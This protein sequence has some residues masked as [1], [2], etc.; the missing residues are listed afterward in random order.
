MLNQLPLVDM[1]HEI[2]GNSA[3]VTSHELD[4]PHPGFQSPPGLY[5]YILFLVGN[6]YKPSF[7]AV[8]GWGLDTNYVYVDTE[9]C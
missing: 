5:I 8:A 6:P 4:L 7:A 2:A 3:A 9:S 1:D